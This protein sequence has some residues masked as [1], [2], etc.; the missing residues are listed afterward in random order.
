MATLI[1]AQRAV[2][3]EISP[4]CSERRLG[5]PKSLLDSVVADTSANSF[6]AKTPDG[7]D[8]AR[9][10][11]LLLAKNLMR[12]KKGTNSLGALITSKTSRPD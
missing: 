7:G 5:Q 1:E 3:N 12:T 10:F 4:A 2:T 8:A 11:T 9:A 6:A